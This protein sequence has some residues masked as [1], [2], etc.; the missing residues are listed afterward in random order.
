MGE[1]LV[2]VAGLTLE[3]LFVDLF[4]LQRSTCCFN[5]GNASHN[6]PLSPS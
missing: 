1:R 5:K 6:R 4:D 3:F 2:H